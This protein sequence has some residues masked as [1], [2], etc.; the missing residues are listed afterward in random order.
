M[1]ELFWGKH[2]VEQSIFYLHGALHLFDTGTE[3]EKEVY[4]NEQYL[5]TRIK[6]RIDAEEYPIFVTAGSAE[7]KKTHIRHNLYLSFCYDAL[8]KI[9]GSL[10]VF[11]FGF[12]EYD[13]HI[14]DAINEAA[15]YGQ[16]VPNRLWSIYVGV[17]SDS[18]L[19]HVKEIEGRFQVKVNAFDARTTGVW[20][21]AG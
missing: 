3:V 19:T 20:G 1:N 12:G 14:I 11:G 7:Q 4:E 5:L 6:E 13:A 17:N 10:I 16:N 2:S 18:G 8:A 21:A 15:H 9:T